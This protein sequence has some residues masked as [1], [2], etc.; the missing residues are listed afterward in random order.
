VLDVCLQLG[1]GRLPFLPAIRQ[2][3]RDPA[4]LCLDGRTRSPAQLTRGARG[5]LGRCA[6]AQNAGSRLSTSPPCRE[7]LDAW[8]GDCW[9]F[10][11]LQRAPV[12][13]AARRR[14]GAVNDLS[15]YLLALRRDPDLPR[16]SLDGLAP[17]GS[18]ILDRPEPCCVAADNQ[19]SRSHDHVNM[20][21]SRLALLILRGECIG[22]ATNG[23]MPR[24]FI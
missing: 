10:A 18:A 16:M 14:T 15:A 24:W 3:S 11:R 13:A 5:R 8:H 17:V 1:R 21:P 22:S 2:R 6:Y 7:E 20:S 4:R 9:E 23:L 19:R 12:I